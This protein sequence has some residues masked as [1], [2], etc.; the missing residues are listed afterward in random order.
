[1]PKKTKPTDWSRDYFTKKDDGKFECNFGCG[2]KYAEAASKFKN[3]L[4]V[5]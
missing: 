1:M 4:L 5:G 2:A 3:H